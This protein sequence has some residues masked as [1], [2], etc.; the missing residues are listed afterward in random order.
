MTTKSK[1]IIE[2]VLGR[3]KDKKVRRTSVKTNARLTL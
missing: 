2:N 1:L 3:L